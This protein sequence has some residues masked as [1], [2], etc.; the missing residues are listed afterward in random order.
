MPTVKLGRIRLRLGRIFFTLSG[1][2][3]EITT[4]FFQRV[5]LSWSSQ[6]QL[7]CEWL[8][9][10]C[11]FIIRLWITTIYKGIEMKLFQ[12]CQNDTLD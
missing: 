8:T 11:L 5:E 6:I 1:F 12:N 3:I 10:A 7:S 9:E 4:D 2:P